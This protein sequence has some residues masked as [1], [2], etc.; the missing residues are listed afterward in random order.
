MEVVL[1]GGGKKMQAHKRA[2]AL[3][4]ITGNCAVLKKQKVAFAEWAAVCA[5]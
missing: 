4:P 3:A 1:V 2:F 5:Y